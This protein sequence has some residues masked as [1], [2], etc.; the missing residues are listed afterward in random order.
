[1]VGEGDVPKGERKRSPKGCPIPRR[2][3]SIA[4]NHALL[5]ACHGCLQ[6][7]SVYNNCIICLEHLRIESLHKRFFCIGL[8]VKRTEAAINDALSVY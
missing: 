8:K 2:L 7:S 5:S 4:L 6:V 3:F 1:M